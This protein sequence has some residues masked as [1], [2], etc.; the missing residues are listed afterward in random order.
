M[1]EMDEGRGE[2]EF[3]VDE[4]LQRAVRILLAERTTGHGS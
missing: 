4:V 2:I 3:G 1:N